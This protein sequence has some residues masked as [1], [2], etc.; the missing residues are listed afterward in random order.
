MQDLQEL[1]DIKLEKQQ[2]LQNCSLNKGY[3]CESGIVTFGWSLE[4][5]LE[6]SL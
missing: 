3:C 2:Y 5:M 1:S 4:I 6:Q